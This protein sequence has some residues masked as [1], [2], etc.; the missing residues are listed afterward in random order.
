LA[1]MAPHRKLLYLEGPL[2][3]AI[4][5]LI[6]LQLSGLVGGM[7]GY[8]AFAASVFKADTFLGIGLFSAFVAYD[9]HNAI[10]MY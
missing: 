5:G 2:M 9:T 4:T 7:M 10:R 8:S 1:Y 6:V 3:G